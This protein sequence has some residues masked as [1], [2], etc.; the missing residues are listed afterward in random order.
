MNLSIVLKVDGSRIMGWGN[1]LKVFPYSLQQRF[2]SH[3]LQNMN[4][5][6]VL[7]VDGTRIMG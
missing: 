6:V 2:D 4:L 3:H 7:K 5:S 1:R